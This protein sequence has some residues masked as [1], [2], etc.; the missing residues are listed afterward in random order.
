MVLA[1]VDLEIESIV[2]QDDALEIQ[3]RTPQVATTCPSCGNVSRS[4]HSYYVRQP[5]DL[6][7]GC[8]PT[9]FRLR[10]KRFRCLIPTCP[11]ATFVEPLPG[12]LARYSRRSVRLAAVLETIIGPYWLALARTKTSQETRLSRA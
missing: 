6:P 5:T 4:I 7:V 8:R 11:R 3:A 2:V 10:V 12:F 9:R 1:L